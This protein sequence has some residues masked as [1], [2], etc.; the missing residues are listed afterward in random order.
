MV[1]WGGT[2]GA[3]PFNDGSRYNPGTDTWT[4]MLASPLTQRSQAEAVAFGPGVFLFGGTDGAN[5][6]NTGALYVP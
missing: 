6:L 3:V 1:V 4:V 5:P 2:D